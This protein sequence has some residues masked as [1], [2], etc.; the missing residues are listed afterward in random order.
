VSG[1][2][3]YGRHVDSQRGG[4]EFVDDVFVAVVG[5]RI[6]NLVAYPFTLVGGGVDVVDVVD[7]VGNG[8]VGVTVDGLWVGCDYGVCVRVVVCSFEQVDFAYLLCVVVGEGVVDVF[9]PLGRCVLLLP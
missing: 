6:F 1:D 5:A 7:V 3:A 8:G 4:P 2:H 9:E